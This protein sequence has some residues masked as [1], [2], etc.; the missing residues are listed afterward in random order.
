MLVLTEAT[1]N[2]Q[3]VLG[4]AITTSQ[5]RCMSVWRDITTTVYTPGRTVTNT[6]STTDVNIV[7]SPGASTQRVVDFINIYNSDTAA[8]QVI[9]K[10]DANGTE[11]ILWT[12][13][14]LV[15]ESV[16]YV[17]GTGWQ[18]LTSGGVPMVN[19]GGQVDV[20]SSTTAGAGTWTKPTTFTPKFTQVVAYG[21]GGGG[22]GVG[23]NTGLGGAG[24]LGGVGAIYIISW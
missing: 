18:K 9:V 15:G 2:L 24:G 3:V 1:D 5:L 6:N 12:A 11:Y 16:Q 23:S 10:F 13:T 7:P 19:S 14:L 21:G 20:Q 4:G 8:S 22:G 17:E